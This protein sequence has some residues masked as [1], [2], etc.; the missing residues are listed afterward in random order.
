[1]TKNLGNCC[2]ELALRG[3]SR[4][5]NETH[6][7]KGNEMYIEASSHEIRGILDAARGVAGKRNSA[8]SV[9]VFHGPRTMNSY[10]DEGSRDEFCL[11]ELRTLKS[12][13]V[14]T[15]HPYFDRLPSGDRCGNLQLS[16]LP[17]NTCLVE[18]GYCRGKAR[19]FRLHFREENLAKLLPA[20]DANPMSDSAK[21]ALNIIASYRGGYRA[22]EFAR[23]GL[24]YYGPQ[25]PSV[26]ELQKAGLVSINKA[27]SI[28]VTTAGRNAR[29]Y[30]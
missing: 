14:P 18:G 26:Q 8:V 13:Q 7:T 30:A 17:P 28:Q 16:E 1:M 21:S 3:D 29:Q 10:W 2:H 25:N 15:S 12:W 23:S 20:P 5:V 11:V 9:G 6:S 19:T 22:D 4:V 27:G 24:G